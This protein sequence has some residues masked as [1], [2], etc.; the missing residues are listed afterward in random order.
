LFNIS[1]ET[2]LIKEIKDIR[3]ELHIVST[4][5]GDQEKV[6]V[7][8]ENTIQAMRDSKE[9]LTNA[10]GKSNELQSTGPSYHSLLGRVRRHISSVEKLETQAEKTYLAVSSS[11][12]SR[13]SSCLP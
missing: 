9:K 2:R 7:D 11:L 8:M 12:I 3:D 4:V 1:K 6:L 5:L 13:D 10:D